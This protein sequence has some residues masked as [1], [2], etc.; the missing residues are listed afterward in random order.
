VRYAGDD[1]VPLADALAAVRAEL[2]L[3]DGDPL[4]ALERQWHEVVGADVAE[5]AR[6]DSLRDGTMT[7]TADGPIWG[8]QLRYL[9]AEI[10]RRARE[11]T[12]S[13][14]IVAV[15]VRVGHEE[16]PGRPRA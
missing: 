8:T 13:D 12:G 3:P 16:R 4:G 7:I 6:P 10:I 11:V 14:A 15:K 1:P 5:H 2:G 9:E